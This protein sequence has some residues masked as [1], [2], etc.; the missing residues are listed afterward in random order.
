MHEVI[1][2]YLYKANIMLFCGW[3]I[4]NQVVRKQPF[5]KHRITQKSHNFH[6]S[7]D[8]VGLL[9]W[10]YKILHELMVWEAD[11][12]RWRNLDY[13]WMAKKWV[14]PAYS[15]PVFL[16]AKISLVHQANYGFIFLE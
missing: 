1:Q 8:F 12:G 16:L 6:G 15:P 4:A 14:E 3:Y 7:S 13:P 9:S 10:M 11:M 2:L 5:P